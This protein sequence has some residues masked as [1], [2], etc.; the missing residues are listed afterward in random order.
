MSTQTLRM[1]VASDIPPEL[2]GLLYDKAQSDT[3]HIVAVAGPPGSGKSTLSEQLCESLNARLTGDPV[4]VLP[5]DGYHLDNALLIEMDALERKGAPHTFDVDGFRL[6][7]QRVSDSTDEIVIPV[8]DRTLDLARA[9]G[10]CI[11]KQHKLILVEGNYLLLDQPKW[12]DLRPLFDYSIYLDVTESVLRERLTQRWLDHGM[13]LPD[14][15]RRAEQNDIPNAQL[16]A[17]N[18]LQADLILRQD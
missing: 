15:T 9:G 18:R 17:S 7:L 4:V 8:F 11:K 1:D 13:P 10:R 6:L 14:A 5:M 12:R 2:T 16:V 3:R